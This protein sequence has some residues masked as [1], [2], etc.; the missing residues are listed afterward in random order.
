M[1]WTSRV[2]S[3]IILQSYH[4]SKSSTDD[5]KASR[6]IL[7]FSHAF[8]IFIVIWCKDK[9]GSKVQLVQRVWCHLQHYRQPCVRPVVLICMILLPTPDISCHQSQ[10]LSIHVPS[11]AHTHTQTSL[12][13]TYLVC[14]WAG[15]QVTLCMVTRFQC[16]VCEWVTFIVKITGFPWICL[17]CDCFKLTLLA[18]CISKITVQVT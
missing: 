5:H 4:S 8:Y 2:H 3:K 6:I 14:E 16:L 9:V 12:Y 15:N 1:V 18:Y 7:D 10:F 17:I 11:H 13:I